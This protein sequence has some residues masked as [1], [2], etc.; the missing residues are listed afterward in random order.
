M[1]LQFFI[2]NYI[3]INELK[4]IEKEF[5]VRIPGTSNLITRF[6]SFTGAVVV[7]F[8]ASF[9]PKSGYSLATCPMGVHSRPEKSVR[10]FDC[11]RSALATMSNRDLCP[12]LLKLRFVGFNR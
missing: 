7:E 12:T 1:Y 3:H 4:N 10:L 11:E 8:S 5:H 9:K 6:S 2:S